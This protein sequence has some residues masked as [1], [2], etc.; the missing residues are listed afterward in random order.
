ML[1]ALLTPGVVEDF[2]DPCL[3]DQ[4]GLVAVGG[5]LSRERLLLAYDHGI[6]PWFNEGTPELWWSPDP[7]AVLL[8]ENLHVSRSMQ[9]L[10]AKCP[11]EVTLNTSFPEVMMGCSEARVDGTWILPEM[12]EAYSVLNVSGDAHSVEVWEQGHLVGGI[13]GVQRGALFAGESMFHRRDN[14]SK[15]ALIILVRSLAAAG[16]ELIDVQMMTSHLSTMGAVTIP[17][18]DYVARISSLTNQPVRLDCLVAGD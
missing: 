18:A 7:R 12:I 16:V 17:R 10:L 1:P 13:Y 4:D 15:V 3:A 14:A 6:F 11:Y 8:P 5:D 9:K 2:P